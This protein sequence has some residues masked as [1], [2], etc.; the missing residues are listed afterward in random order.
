MEAA[1]KPGIKQI[2]MQSFI[3][4]A[5]AVNVMLGAL[6]WARGQVSLPATAPTTTV[7]VL[8]GEK[9]EVQDRFEGAEQ[10]GDWRIE[11][12]EKVEYRY[13]RYGRLL[14]ASPTGEKTYLRYWDT[15]ERPKP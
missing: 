10:H 3:F 6:L 1:M 12:Y 9:V 15:Q 5:L 7:P 4:T 2:L 11:T 13:D 8:P 14:E